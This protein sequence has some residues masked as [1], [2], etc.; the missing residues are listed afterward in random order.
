MDLFEPVKRQMALL[1]AYKFPATWLLQYDAMVS[2]PF[3]GFLKE[4]MPPSHE[5]GLWFEMNEDHCKAAGVTWRGRP[6]YEWDWSPPVA[7]SLGYTPDERNKLV[8]AAAAKFYE[9]WGRYPRS[10]ASWNLDALSISRFASRYGVEAFAVC[11]DQIATD[12]F[13]IWGAPI[14]GYYPSKTNCWSPALDAENQIDVPVFRMLGQDPVYYYQRRYP[15]PNGEISGDP[16]TMEPVWPSGRSPE[17]VERFFRMIEEAPCGEFAYLQLGQEN[18]FGWPAMA[19]GFE[20]QMRKLAEIESRQLLEPPAAR[21]LKIETLSSTGRRFRR[22]FKM[23]PVQAQV[24]L[25]DPFGHCSTPERSVWYQSRFYRANL[26]FKGA[27]PFFRDIAVYSDAFPQP[28]LRRPTR[29][30]D[31]EQ[32]MPAILDGCHWSESEAEPAAGGLLRDGEAIRM[33]G[34]PRV[35]ET[36]FGLKVVIPCAHPLTIHFREREIAIGSSQ[37]FRL[38]FAWDPAKAAFTGLQGSRAR[39]EWQGFEYAVRVSQGK[40]SASPRGWSIDP[41]QGRIRMILG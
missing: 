6:G 11:R 41:G 25:A 39:Y 29:Q 34:E 9:L 7:F 37:P 31:V 40:A 5:V 36:A 35:S 24:Q 23:T 16:D 3:V 12:G 17:F 27:L 1:R 30:T 2:G 26:H 32:R 15:L 13:T 18:S 28:F 10:V 19:D 8:D 14:A 38:V 20:M 21:R 4:N 33:S 22:A